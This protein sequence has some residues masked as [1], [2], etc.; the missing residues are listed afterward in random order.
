M[1]R[2]RRNGM[3]RPK[4]PITWTRFRLPPN[5]EWPH[6]LCP[7]A[8]ASHDDVESKLVDPLQ[9]VPGVSC[10][11]MTLGKMVEFP[12]EAV[13]IIQWSFME[14]LTDFL[15]SPACDTFLRLLDG[16]EQHDAAAGD[17]NDNTLDEAEAT[18]SSKQQTE[19]PAMEELISRRRRRFLVLKHWEEAATSD[20]EGRVTMTTF[21][22][23]VADDRY[24]TLHEAYLDVRETFGRFDVPNPPDQDWIERFGRAQNSRRVWFY[25][26]RRGAAEEAEKQQD[27]SSQ[28]WLEMTFGRGESGGAGG[29][30]P[31]PLVQSQVDANASAS[32]APKKGLMCEFRVWNDFKDANVN[33][34]S[35][36]KHAKDAE[37][38]EKWNKF[39]G[40]WMS[41]GRILAWKRERWDFES[42]RR[43]WERERHSEKRKREEAVDT[44]T[45]S[46]TRG[47]P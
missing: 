33:L 31:L 27:M 8:T 22:I 16:N 43:F 1:A 40:Q 4:R 17:G 21:V 6:W 7:G 47:S 35:E 28:T 45:D 32:D 3:D 37:I 13:C 14:Y 26:P 15:E 11:S 30:L 29:Q 18:N 23:P 42:V 39:V 44:V 5:Q 19:P 46:E 25:A 10:Y 34:A 38:K 2:T 20:I 41:D 9:D 36:E 12:Q 24:G